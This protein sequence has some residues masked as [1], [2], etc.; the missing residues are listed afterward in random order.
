MATQGYGI[1]KNAG[2]KIDEAIKAYRQ[3]VW[4]SLGNFA[5][6]FQ[7]LAKNEVIGEKSYKELDSL[8]QNHQ[9]RMALVMN[10]KL[11]PLQKA[12]WT[13]DQQYA[14][15]DDEQTKYL[16]HRDSKYRR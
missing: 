2:N 9:Q 11:L 4:F 8:L 1:A 12:A 10:D 3:T 16:D 15:L 7:T 6:A 13:L 5:T 14:R